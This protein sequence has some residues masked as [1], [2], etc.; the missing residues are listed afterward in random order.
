MR[1][2]AAARDSGIRICSCRSFAPKGI[3]C[4]SIIGGSGYGKQIEALKKGV[5]VLI[6][7]PGRLIDFMEQG[8]ADFSKI[9]G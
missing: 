6:A 2:P 5:T 3:T 7:T 1:R 4:A 9:E 8:L